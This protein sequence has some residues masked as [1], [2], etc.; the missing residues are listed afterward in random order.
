M[1]VDSIREIGPLEDAHVQVGL[2]HPHHCQLE[3]SVPSVHILYDPNRFGVQ[4]LPL[5][6]L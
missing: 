1:G 3:S 5:P 6:L 4:V 2:G